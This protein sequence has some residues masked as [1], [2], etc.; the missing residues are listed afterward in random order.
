MNAKEYLINVSPSD[1]FGIRAKLRS[2][3]LLNIGCTLMEQ[4]ARYKI[5]ILNVETKKE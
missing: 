1:K 3:N 2:K 5:E 4:Y